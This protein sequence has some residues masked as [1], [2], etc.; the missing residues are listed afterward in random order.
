MGEPESL[1]M[2]LK[3]QSIQRTLFVSF[4][5]LL[6]LHFGCKP[7]SA[8][9]SL[10]PPYDSWPTEA[11]QQLDSLLQIRQFFIQNEVPPGM[12]SEINGQI[13][14]YLT[15]RNPEEGVKYFEEI[16]TYNYDEEQWDKAALMHVRLARIYDRNLNN[17]AEALN[18]LLKAESL[19]REKGRTVEI[20]EVLLYQATLEAKLGRVEE[21][22]SKGR[23]AMS[24]FIRFKSTPGISKSCFA[25]ASV[26]QENDQADSSLVYIN[27]ARS[28]WRTRD[29]VQWLFEANN[30]KL[31]ILMEMEQW[32]QAT[33]VVAENKSIVEQNYIHWNPRLAFFDLWSK[34][35]KEHG[36]KDELEKP[37]EW[38]KLLRDSLRNEAI[39]LK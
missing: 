4:A 6:T 36:T 25:L 20:A 5:L 13:G 10:Q 28:G 32:E 22:L 21:G 39:L 14:L 9:L 37:L 19:W 17:P 38:S 24:S 2:S 26:F 15:D 8:D 35:V 3:K 29:A 30:I 7:E 34:L 12:L 16:L 27:K 31:E 23:E 18:H 11:Y 1:Q 33:A